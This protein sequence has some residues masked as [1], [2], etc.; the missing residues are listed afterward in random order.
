MVRAL[1]LLTTEQAADIADKNAFTNDTDNRTFL[2]VKNASGATDYDVTITPLDPADVD[3]LD[4]TIAPLV[5]TVVKSTTR[6]IGPFPA[7]IYTQADGKVWVD[8]A[9]ASLMLA[10]VRVP[11]A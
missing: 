5:V 3:G 1:G 6:Y 9:N 8:G 2:R 7:A 10:A 11:N 4:V